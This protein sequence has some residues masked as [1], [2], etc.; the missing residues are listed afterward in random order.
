MNLD[1]KITHDNH[2]VD[3]TCRYVV[4]WCMDVEN[5]VRFVGWQD[6]WISSTT[7][8]KRMFSLHALFLFSTLFF[9]HTSLHSLNCNWF[10]CC[11]WCCDP[12]FDICSSGTRSSTSWYHRPNP[13]R[14]IMTHTMAPYKIRLE[15]VIYTHSCNMY[16]RTWVILH[17][18]AFLTNWQVGHRERNYKTIWL[19]TTKQGSPQSTPPQVRPHHIIV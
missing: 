6:L 3:A 11:K 19:A 16:T 10:W 4:L 8:G 7:W 5:S 13:P 1:L 14:Q 9:V 15:L 12:L 2:P 17:V 18:C